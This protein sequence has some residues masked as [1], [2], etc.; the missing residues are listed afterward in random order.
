MI[1]NCGHF[2]GGVGGTGGLSFA[3]F[4]EFQHPEFENLVHQVMN[5]GGELSCSLGKEILLHTMYLEGPIF[6]YEDNGHHSYEPACAA[7]H[8][9]MILVHFSGV[10]IAVCGFSLLIQPATQ[11]EAETF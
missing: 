4:L 3:A 8:S 6:F 11:P 7:T 5:N 1:F 10:F 2:A 9:G